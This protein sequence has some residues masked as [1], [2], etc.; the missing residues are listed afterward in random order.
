MLRAT[1]ND[2]AIINGALGFGERWRDLVLACTVRVMRH[3]PGFVVADA[4]WDQRSVQGESTAPILHRLNGLFSRW[5]VR[6]LL[7]DRA[8]LCFLSKEEAQHFITQ[9]RCSRESAV[10]TPFTSTIPWNELDSLF[11]AR[12][13][14]ERATSDPYIFSGGNT[15]R[16]WDL[17]SEA[18]GDCGVRVRVA[19]RHVDRTWPSNFDVGPCTQAE[20]LPL[21]AGAQICVFALKPDS[22]RSAG[23]QTYL[24]ALRLGCPVV[25]NDAAG[26]RD[27]LADIPGAFITPTN[28][29]SAMRD[30]VAWLLDPAN[31]AEVDGLSLS[32]ATFVAK[33]FSESNYL[34]QL[35]DIADA[36]GARLAV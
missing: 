12:A 5:L 23:Q 20:F 36:L 13:A 1:N 33:N 22:V 4:T 25:V 18:L 31:A 21:M 30:I 9:T 6:R 17:L 14:G 27:H 11:A 7:G 26:V 32:G 3:Q 28:D 35:A 2:V 15:L 8:V 29:A 19:T 10:F 34:G 24:N 16:D